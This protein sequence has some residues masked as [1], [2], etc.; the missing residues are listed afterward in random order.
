MDC[1]Y[2]SWTLILGVVGIGPSGG[3]FCKTPEEGNYEEH[4]KA[5]RPGGFGRVSVEEDGIGINVMPSKGGVNGAG[6]SNWEP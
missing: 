6:Q 1:T 2:P 5:P 3:G 4:G